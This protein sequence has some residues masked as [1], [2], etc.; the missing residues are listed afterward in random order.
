MHSNFIFLVV[1]GSVLIVAMYTYSLNSVFADTV[2]TCTATSKKTTSCVVNDSA[3]PTVPGSKWDCKLNK[4]GKTWSCKQAQ[5]RTAASI[6]P[7]LDRALDLAV[8]AESHNATKVPKS[9]LL[10]KGD[11]LNEP[12]LTESNNDSNTKVPKH[13][14]DLKN[15]NNSLTVNPE[16]Q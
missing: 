5:A 9:D 7:E 12:A 6:S 14:D 11:L 1:I 10:K 15:D 16:L 8:Q 13:L 3:D 4:D 2:T